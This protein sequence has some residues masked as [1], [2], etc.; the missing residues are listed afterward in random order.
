MGNLYFV[1]NAG[2]GA[3]LAFDHNAVIVR[4]LD[5]LLGQRNVVLEGL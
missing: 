1:L 5:D 4:V 2:Q 3:Q